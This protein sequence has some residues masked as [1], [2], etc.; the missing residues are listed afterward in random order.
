MKKQKK[1]T[2]EEKE[3]FKKDWINKNKSFNIQKYNRSYQSLKGM[4]RILGLKKPKNCQ[5]RYK[6]KIL[7]N[8]SITSLYWLGFI[9]ADGHINSGGELKVTLSELDELHIRRL[10]KYLNSNVNRQIPQEKDGY[11]SKPTFSTSCKDSFY[12]IKILESF[13]VVHPK[14]Y[15][16]ISL[17][18][19][20]TKDHFFSFLSGLID[21]DGCFCKDKN[22]KLVMIRIQC[23]S[24]WLS[25]YQEIC[26][27]LK[28][29]DIQ[30]RVYIDTQ[31]YSRF[32]I[33]SKDN[34]L[35]LN[36]IISSLDIPLLLRKWNIF[37]NF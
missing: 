32:V 11:T 31:G 8:K 12:G 23:H 2:I 9:M 3:S 18:Y 1:W 25:V 28:V 10:A 21:G 24:S 5:N 13:S 4:A 35:R 34:F 33:T 37:K 14:T 29:Y 36:E 15:N 26:N 17:K 27:R 19:L 22:G 6:L 7:L 16:P 30:S 20:K